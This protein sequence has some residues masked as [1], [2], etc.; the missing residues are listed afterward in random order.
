MF[1]QQVSGLLFQ[2]QTSSCSVSDIELHP[3]TLCG[4]KRIKRVDVI[5]AQISLCA[6]CL[7]S[8][9][10]SHQPPD[11]TKCKQLD[12]LSRLLSD[13]RLPSPTLWVLS[14][15]EANKKSSGQHCP[16]IPLCSPL[17]AH[18]WLLVI[19]PRLRKTFSQLDFLSRR[20]IDGSG[21]PDIK[22]LFTDKVTMSG[23]RCPNSFVTSLQIFTV[24]SEGVTL[25]YCKV[26]LMS[27]ELSFS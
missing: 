1:C 21:Y 22:H 18:R 16:D 27:H 10:M 9:L 3:P 2:L 14:S 19:N 17:S 5:A 6:E 23:Q 20:S 15:Q 26:Y 4:Q 8:S 13:I 12:L 25:F 7:C 24:V 11:S